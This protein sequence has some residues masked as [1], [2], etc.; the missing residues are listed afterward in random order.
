MAHPQPKIM[1]VDDDDSLRFTFTTILEDA[2]FE[3]TA[4]SDGLEGVEMAAKHHFDLI[5]LDVRMPGLG[6][7]EACRRIKEISPD[8]IIILLT[9]LATQAL[10]DQALEEGAFAVHHKPFDVW[11]L[12]NL[13][14]TVMRSTCVLVVDDQP[15]TRTTMRAIL[16]D[17]GHQVS[18]AE[19]GYEAVSK[20]GKTRFDIILMD[21]VM[22][23][24]DGFAAG[25]KIVEKTRMRK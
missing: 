2:G 15:E 13:V 23:G 18:E 4:A 7:I 22:P 8:T 10:I 12:T 5:F 19:N 20:A 6:G 11:K 9:A 24:M 3:V 17:S 21:A 1:V 16:E 25:Q 14:R